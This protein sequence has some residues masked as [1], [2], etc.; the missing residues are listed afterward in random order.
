LAIVVLLR[1]AEPAGRRGAE[2]L[3]SVGFR[4]DLSGDRLSEERHN[5]TPE[6]A[7]AAGS[8]ATWGD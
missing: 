6:L 3:L 7:A 4:R 5:L 2:R 8:G 1:A